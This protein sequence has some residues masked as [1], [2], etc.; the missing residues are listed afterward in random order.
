MAIV[1]QVVLKETWGQNVIL[2]IEISY[3]CIELISE[4]QEEE[5]WTE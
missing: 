1:L 4:L 2:E 5:G 3:R